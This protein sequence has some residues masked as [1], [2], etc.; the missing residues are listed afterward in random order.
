MKSYWR[1]TTC[2]VERIKVWNALRVNR[3]LSK[4]L[5]LGLEEK[6]IRISKRDFKI[7]NSLLTGQLIRLSFEA[8]DHS[9]RSV[10]R[11]RILVTK[12][13][14]SKYK[15][16]KTDEFWRNHI[17]VKRKQIIGGGG[18]GGSEVKVYDVA[19]HKVFIVNLSS[20]TCIFSIL[21]IFINQIMYP[22]I[23]QRQL[24]KRTNITRWE[25]DYY[26]IY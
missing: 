24:K 10:H 16:S 3:P 1:V 14:I 11:C 2:L 23:I 26:F 5:L 21:F 19:C 18:G 22:C 4:K 20:S 15:H 8:Y 9:L 7:K 6:F 12:I 17:Q 25:Q 13:L